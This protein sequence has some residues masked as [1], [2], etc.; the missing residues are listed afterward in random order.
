ML[1]GM[2]MTEKQ[3]GS[4]LRSNTTS[5]VAA[6]AGSGWYSLTGHKWFFSVPTSDVHLLLARDGEQSYSCFYVSRWLP[7]GR[8][9][10]IHIKR[11]KANMVNRSH[12]SDWKSQLLNSSH[13]SAT[14]IQ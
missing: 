3:G 13:Y 8:R 12:T 7:D 5:A 9:K 10:A 14:I 1:I 4:D 2:G 11:L 6:D